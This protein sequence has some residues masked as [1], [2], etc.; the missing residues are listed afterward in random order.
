MVKNKFIELVEKNAQCERGDIEE[1]IR[2]NGLNLESVIAYINNKKKNDNE[3]SQ[4][5][6]DDGFC[7]ADEVAGDQ[8]KEKD[9]K[10][11]KND[12]DDGYTP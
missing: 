12:H 6:Y 9:L 1:A 4:G 3:K 10:Q 11:K 2:E 8:K 5:L 7:P